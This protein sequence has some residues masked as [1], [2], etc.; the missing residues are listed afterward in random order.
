MTGVIL[1]K[2]D[3]ASKLRVNSGFERE[4]S[5]LHSQD[6]KLFNS[7]TKDYRKVPKTYNS[8]HIY[9]YSFGFLAYFCTTI[10]MV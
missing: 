1:V 6:A 10:A 5:S 8:D 7:N 4:T 9:D 3:L 2:V